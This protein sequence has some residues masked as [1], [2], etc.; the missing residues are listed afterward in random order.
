MKFME[1]QPLASP[2]EGVVA[3]PAAQRVARG[4]TGHGPWIAAAF[5]AGLLL[6]SSCAR[7]VAGRL[8]STAATVAKPMLV[9]AGLAK[10][11]HLLSSM[12]SRPAKLATNPSYEKPTLE[13][14]R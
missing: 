4:H 11:G 5:A 3:T 1:E 13:P 10:L 6:R 2:D 14:L 8:I 7:A 9:T 12:P